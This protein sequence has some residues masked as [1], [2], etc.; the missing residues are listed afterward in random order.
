MADNR[1]MLTSEDILAARALS[2]ALSGPQEGWKYIHASGR[3]HYFRDGRSLCKKWTPIAQNGL[4][5]QP[6]SSQD[7]CAP[8][9][10][11]RAQERGHG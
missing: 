10:R 1:R 9:T 6:D 3:R 11:L 7:N 2:S 5:A 8:C 4:T